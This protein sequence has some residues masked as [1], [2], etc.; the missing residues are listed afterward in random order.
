MATDNLSPA[1][2]STYSSDTMYVGDGTWDATKNDFLLPNLMGLNFATMRYNGMGNRFATMPGYRGL[3]AAHGIL[4]AITFLIVVPAA[5]MIARFYGRNIRNALRYH[6]YLQIFTLLMSTAVFTLG[7]MAVGRARSLTNPHHGI[8]LAIY[9]L[10]WFQ[11]LSGWWTHSREKSRVIKRI[12]LKLVL[13]QWIGRA[14]ALLAIAQ[15]PLGLTL[16]GSPEYLFILYAVW[17][18][19]LVFLYFVLS[20]RALQVLPQ[21]LRE[22]GG[23]GSVVPERR[24]S[25]WG[26]ILGPLAA[27]AGAAALLGRNRNRSRSRSRSRVR[28][29]VIASRR[30]SRRGSESYIDE[31]K[32]ET[33]KKEGGGLMDKL[34]KGA[35]VLGA[36]ALAKSL[37][38]GRKRKTNDDEYSSVAHDTP[39]RRRHR[40]NSSSISDTTIDIERTERRTGG[41][42]LPGPGGPVAAA[43]AISAAEPRP[44]TP[45]PSASRVTRTTRSHR[46]HSWDSDY[47]SYDSGTT[48]PSRRMSPSRRAQEESNG[49]RNG[50]LAGLGIG[51]FTKRMRDR[52]EKKEQER[53][54]REEDERYERE[55]AARRADTGPRYTG[56][57]YPSRT[58]ARRNSRAESSDL[59]SIVEPLPG[60][61]ASIP[62]VTAGIPPPQPHQDITTPIAMPAAPPDPHG[63]LHETDSELTPTPGRSRRRSSV[64]RREGEDA[65]AA[66]VAGAAALAAEEERRRQR[67]HSRSAVA[68]P[69]VSVKV[70]MH[71]DKDR[72]VTLRRLTEQEAAAE[73]AARRR[74][75]HSRAGSAG[76]FSEPESSQRYRRAASERRAES[77]ARSEKKDEA[78]LPPPPMGPLTPPT[79]AFAEGR[80]PKDSAYYSGKPE[81]LAPSTIIGAPQGAGQAG[82]AGSVFGAKTGSFISEDTHGTWSAMS[83]DGSTDHAADRR[84]RRRL[85][86]MRRD[87]EETGT[88]TVLGSVD[89]Q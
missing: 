10:I 74:Q 19:F 8:G 9:V 29:E 71:G 21:V 30:G 5:V 27:G 15:V 51:W 77:L 88:G 58:Q 63:I 47:Y 14:T 40:R 22:A 50:L 54:D 79:P 44:T 82:Q 80:K 42:I 86:R 1:G 17:M 55:R 45:R 26:G 36:G 84:R 7:W 61:R 89:Y 48:S 68:S 57:G 2:S 78:G 37:Y 46:S 49:L 87:G 25:S 3:I 11:F 56:D 64:R 18:A 28:T 60:P 41:P 43:A 35:A 75:G 72:N 32:Y 33:R 16:Y 12:P 83:K 38:D 6:I 20:Y 53:L 67:S 73:R 85:E 81:S 65:A 59:S 62:P 24:K 4:A 76:S 69:P 31:E 70:K 13:H 39:G 23:H 66:A 52:R 34:F